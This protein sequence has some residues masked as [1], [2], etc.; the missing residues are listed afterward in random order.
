MSPAIRHVAGRAP[1]QAQ[2]QLENLKELIRFM[3]EFDTLAGFLEHVRLVMDAQTEEG[4]DRVSLMTL[5]AA[6]G[7]EFD[8]VFLPGWEEGLFPHQRSLDEAGRRPRGGAPAR[9]C[10][11]D[12]GAE[13][14]QDSLNTGTRHAILKRSRAHSSGIFHLTSP[15]CRP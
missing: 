7:L 15:R 13:A 8:T 6:K 3:D 5:H 2:S 9:L 11:A 10:R 4:G 1:P 12:A 14:R